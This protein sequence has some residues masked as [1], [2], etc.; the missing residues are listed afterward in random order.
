MFKKAN[1]LFIV[2]FRELVLGLALVL[3]ES[4]RTSGS[5]CA[6]LMRP[7]TAPSRVPRLD[8]CGTGAPAHSERRS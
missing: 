7:A 5:A 6:R 3:I 1:S 8:R 2:S 4:H